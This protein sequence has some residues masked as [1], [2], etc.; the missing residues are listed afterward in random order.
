MDTLEQ[1]GSAPPSTNR[2]MKN[3]FDFTCMA[4]S[5]WWQ[6]IER[7]LYSDNWPTLLKMQMDRRSRKYDYLNEQ[8]SKQR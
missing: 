4:A 6:D 5:W 2:V 3:S 7:P 1:P 8:G